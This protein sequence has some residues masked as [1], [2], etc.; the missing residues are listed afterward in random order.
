LELALVAWEISD[1]LFGDEKP[2]IVDL[3]RIDH[4][5]SLLEK[6]AASLPDCIRLGNTPTPGAMDLQ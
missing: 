1:Y 6:A 4:F 5:H 3:E 2:P